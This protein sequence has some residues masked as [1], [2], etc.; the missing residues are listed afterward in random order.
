[1]VVDM[2]WIITTLRVKYECS[3]EEKTEGGIYDKPLV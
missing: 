2:E 1:M 3:A